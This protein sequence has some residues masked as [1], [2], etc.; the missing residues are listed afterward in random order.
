MY[1]ASKCDLQ[2]IQ[3]SAW[4][5]APVCCSLWANEK[6]IARRSRT[7]AMVVKCY[8]LLCVYWSRDRLPNATIREYLFEWDVSALME[9][10]HF[11]WLN[12]YALLSS[13]LQKT[14]NATQLVCNAFIPLFNGVFFLINTCDRTCICLLR[15][16]YSSE[17]GRFRV[18]RGMVLQCAIFFIFYKCIRSCETIQLRQTTENNGGPSKNVTRVP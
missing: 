9:G 3:P 1:A 6:E 7:S 17:V 11:K 16:L 13:S 12:P 15:V 5:T 14:W 8:W 18:G 4:E 2:V 10:A